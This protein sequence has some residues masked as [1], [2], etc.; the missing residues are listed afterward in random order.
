MGPPRITQSRLSLL[1]KLQLIF[2]KSVDQKPDAIGGC[3]R[4]IIK[5][6]NAALKADP[7]PVL[8]VMAPC[9]PENYANSLRCIFRN[10]SP[11]FWIH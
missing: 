10:Q 7:A 1:E 6:D 2:L 8:R 11:P 5:T 4:S 9:V 3:Q